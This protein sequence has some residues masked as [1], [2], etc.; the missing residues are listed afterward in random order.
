M[1]TPHSASKL[2]RE[3]DSSSLRSLGCGSKCGQKET[4]SD[5]E[6]QRGPVGQKETKNVTKNMGKLLFKFI[7]KQRRTLG[8]KMGL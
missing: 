5:L 6:Q 3:G 4:L 1:D 2:W 8:Q 7:W